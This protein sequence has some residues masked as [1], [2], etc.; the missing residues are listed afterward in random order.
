MTENGSWKSDWSTDRNRDPTFSGGRPSHDHPGSVNQH[1]TGTGHGGATTHREGVPLTPSST[2]PP[3]MRPPR[4]AAAIGIAIGLKGRHP[5]T[6]LSERVDPIELSAIVSA[7][8]DQCAQGFWA[9]DGVVNKQMGDG[10]MAIFNFPI[11]IECHA[12]AAV[13]AAL[14]F[15]RRCKAALAALAPRLDE[16]LTGALGIGVDVHT[17]LVEIGVFAAEIVRNVA[18]PDQLQPLAGSSPRNLVLVLW[19][20]LACPAGW[21]GGED[22]R[23]ARLLV[24]T[25]HRLDHRE[26]RRR[27]PLIH[28][29]I[30]RDER[31][32]LP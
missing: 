26:G 7:F 18:L 29:A 30:E 9:H 8:Q 19:P 21:R 28:L 5:N 15:Q 2:A 6:Q 12:E 16:A 13:T 4:H 20:G 27:D 23:I 10:L 1:P 17:G 3:P 32:P 22:H 25:V 31:I 24:A 14:D 11:K